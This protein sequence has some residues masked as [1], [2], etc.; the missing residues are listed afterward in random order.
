MNEITVTHTGVLPNFFFMLKNLV[1]F[2]P[3]VYRC[4]NDHQQLLLLNEYKSKSIK[5][6]KAYTYIFYNCQIGPIQCLYCLK[7]LLM[8]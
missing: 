6:L 2:D 8:R 7:A 5:L 1:I 4:E 3:D